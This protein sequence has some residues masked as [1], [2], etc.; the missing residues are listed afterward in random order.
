VKDWLAGVLWHSLMYN[1]GGLLWRDKHQVLVERAHGVGVD[2]QEWIEGQLEERGATG[3][4]D[5][6]ES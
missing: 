5:S 6:L 3:A 4:T 1:T 2:V